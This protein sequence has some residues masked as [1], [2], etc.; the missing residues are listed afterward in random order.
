MQKSKKVNKLTKFKLKQ[1]DM[2]R[3]IAGKHK[4]KEGPITN[5]ISNKMRVAIKGIVSLKHQ[6]PTQSE[7]E[8]GIKEIPATVHISNVALINPKNK[9]KVTKIG[10]KIQDD[11]KKVRFARASGLVITK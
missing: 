4:G 7:Q 5:I 9:K 11:G 8:G 2:V 1:H 10:Y 6:K 3:I